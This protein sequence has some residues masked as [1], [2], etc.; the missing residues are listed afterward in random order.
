MRGDKKG[1]FGSGAC[2]SLSPTA[3]LT[4]SGGRWCVIAHSRDQ[5]RERERESISFHVSRISLNRSIQQ[6]IIGV[7]K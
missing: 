4:V 3:Q 2:F 7:L 5:T 6:G 1:L